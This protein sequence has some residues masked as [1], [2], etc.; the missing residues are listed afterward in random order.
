MTR[1]IRLFRAPGDDLGTWTQADQLAV[2][3]EL[4][5]PWRQATGVLV[6]T[7]ASLLLGFLLGAHPTPAR[8]SWL[9]ALA[10]L[11]HPFTVGFAARATIS[12]GFA[13]AGAI[14][15][16]V[17]SPEYL[18][19]TEFGLQV[20]FLSGTVAAAL[21]FGHA[22]Q[23]LR[24]YSVLKRRRLEEGRAAR[25]AANDGLEAR[26]AE[27]R[28]ELRALA[29]HIAN[30]TKAEQRG[31]RREVR[32]DLLPEIGRLGTAVGGL[33]PDDEPVCADAL[34][35]C[36]A[37][38]R[39]VHLVLRHVLRRLHP[40]IVRRVGLHDAVGAL[41]DDFAR[42]HR[43]A[44]EVS[45]CPLPAAGDH[46]TVELLYGA[47]RDGL[48]RW[49]S[50]GVAELGSVTLSEVDDGL[51]LELEA[52]GEFHPESGVEVVV[53]GLRERAAVLGGELEVSLSPTRSTL[54]LTV[55]HHYEET[56]PASTVLTTDDVS[57]EPAAGDDGFRS[58][59]VEFEGRNYTRYAVVM[60][61]LLVVWWPFDFVLIDDPALLRS[62]IG[63]R[64]SCLVV[65]AAALLIGPIRRHSIQH[66]VG[67]GVLIL[68]SAMLASG[69]AIGTGG[70]LAEG[71]AHYLAFA[72]AL[73]LP[74]VQRPSVQLAMS[75]AV[76]SAG[77]VGFF[78]ATPGVPDGAAVLALLAFSAAM[79]LLHLAVGRTL[80]RQLRA[81]YHLGRELQRQRAQLKERRAELS[82]LVRQQT[83]ELR[84]RAAALQTARDDERA[85]MVHEMHDGLGQVVASLGYTIAH[86]R[87]SVDRGE[88]SDAASSA[89]EAKQLVG[90]LKE[91]LTRILAR[92]GPRRVDDGLTA[93][94][95][96][97]LRSFAPTGEL[98][99]QLRVD[100]GPHR[101]DPELRLLA[102]RVVQEGLSN[103]LK[104]ACA[105]RVTVDLV[106]ERSGLR[107]VVLD[108]GVG[109]A[110]TPAPAPAA[111]GCPASPGASPRR[112]A[113][114]DGRPSPA[115]AP[116]C[117]PTCPGRRGGHDQDPP[118]RRPRAVPRRARAAAGDRAR[119]RGRRRG[120]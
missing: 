80:H 99:T 71:W 115:A 13:A 97:L 15:F 86:V 30:A 14:G 81:S 7:G 10:L 104:H 90:T 98:N 103:I 105:T 58:Y 50:G 33:H 21:I 60:A 106:L 94:L 117:R 70:S 32:R 53:V 102:Y 41:V 96:E 42:K 29:F 64:A 55:P 25:A 54:R 34:D 118:R 35:R 87:R 107:I 89:G 39:R 77:L 75:L 56:R 66:P 45:L 61:A 113:R 47:I 82:M 1:S 40:N 43:V 59:L 16:L 36:D 8:F 20:G 48:R 4:V 91:E 109:L 44:V 68:S 31:L 28:A 76:T 93:A 120:G 22:L 88:R 26:V 95:E 63:F 119:L 24:S 101:L 72:P 74:F 78:A 19:R 52:E 114:W 73:V 9:Y 46:R 3:D 6:V 51:Q 111:W 2:R 83:S 57:K 67:M 69:F 79:V 38:M 27:Q 12:G 11:S 112:A 100:L 116:C 62:M 85:W 23:E 37:A 5:R 49:Q 92:L 65:T 108:D 84:D 17:A 18:E 110:T